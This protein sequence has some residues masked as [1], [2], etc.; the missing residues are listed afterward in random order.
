MVGLFKTGFILLGQFSLDKYGRRPVLL[1]SVAGVTMGLLML[2]LNFTL[3]ADSPAFA[4]GAMIL[5]VSAFAMG[6]GP[7]T[8]VLVSEVI[9]IVIYNGDFRDFSEFREFRDFSGIPGI[10]GIFE[11]FGNFQPSRPRILTE[12]SE[13]RTGSPPPQWGF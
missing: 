7:V 13:I 1:A 5:F 3:P 6:E 11:I 9:N 10:S 4:M 12:K 8:W 2:A